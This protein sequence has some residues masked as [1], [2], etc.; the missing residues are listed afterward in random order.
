MIILLSPDYAKYINVARKLLDSFVK[1]FV[2]I[3]GSHLISHNVHGLIHICDD[4]DK[5]G[6]LDKCAAFPFENYMATLKRMVRKP[7]KPIEPIV[8]RYSEM[9]SLKLNDKLRTFE[10]R[11]AGL[12]N[13]G[14]HLDSTNIIRGH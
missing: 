1:N 9:S 11:F 4:Y 5:F 7:H 3:Y 13:H 2:T 14:P 10:I 12:H 6:S 8:K